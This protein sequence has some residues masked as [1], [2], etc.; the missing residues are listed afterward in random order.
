MPCLPLTLVLAFCMVFSTGIPAHAIT[1]LFADLTNG[2]EVP[3][4]HPSTT[5]GGL[6]PMSFGT[7][8]FALN[9]ARTAMTFSSTIFNIDF[10]GRQTLDTNDNLTVAHIHAGPM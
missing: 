3:P 7:A 9:D 5:T 2:Q 4:T 1:L 10:T 6:R 8:T